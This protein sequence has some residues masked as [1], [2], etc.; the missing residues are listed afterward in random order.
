MKKAGI[1]LLAVITLIF[2]AFTAGFYIGR[3][4]RPSEVQISVLPEVTAPRSENTAAPEYTLPASTEAVVSF[5]IDLN[6]ATKEQLMALP[7]IGETYAQRIL[8]YRKVYGPFEKIGD[9]LNVR[10]IGEK[11]LEEILDLIM[12]GE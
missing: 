11:R 2:I 7:G 12:I 6:T 9:L 4:N 3:V 8:D 1:P 10:G 5:P